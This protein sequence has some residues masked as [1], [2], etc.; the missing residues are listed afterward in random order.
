MGIEEPEGGT[1]QKKRKGYYILGGVRCYSGLYWGSPVEL[2]KCE[3]VNRGEKEETGFKIGVRYICEV[4]NERCQGVR[5]AQSQYR[6]EL[7]SEDDG[8][9]TADRCEMKE[10]GT[11][12]VTST[13]VRS[14]RLQKT[15]RTAIPIVITWCINLW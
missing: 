5:G 13:V 7:I 4:G 14:M 11:T 15:S 1:Q 9:V 8:V 12:G 10:G 6:R 3:C 2:E